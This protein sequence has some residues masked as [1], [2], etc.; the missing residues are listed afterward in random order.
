MVRNQ[1]MALSCEWKKKGM[2]RMDKEE[3]KGIIR[4]TSNKLNRKKRVLCFNLFHC[5]KIFFNIIYK[6]KLRLKI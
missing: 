1:G 4:M 6:N 2:Q 5:L 3:I